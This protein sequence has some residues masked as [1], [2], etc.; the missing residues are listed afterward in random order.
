[1]SAHDLQTR[2]KPLLARPPEFLTINKKYQ[3]PYKIPNRLAVM[4]FSNEEN[5][6]YLEREQRRVHVVKRRDAT[7]A[8]LEYYL[9]ITAWLEHGGAELAAS[10]LL[11]Y[12]LSDAEK[13][14]FIGGV[15]PASD[16]KTEL[17]HLN[18]HPALAA[19]EELFAEGV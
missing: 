7:P 9:A 16:D 17:E 8:T 18:I 11:A 5:P 2:L 1:M 3:S 15:A 14:E 12:P 10:Y 4:L 19:L 13:N 6:L